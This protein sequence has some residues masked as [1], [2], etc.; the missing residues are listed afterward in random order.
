M[1]LR[2]RIAGAAALAVAAVA[3]AVAVISYESTRSHL[4]YN[5]IIVT[6]VLVGIVAGALTS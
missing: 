6:L 4:A 3:A 1:S 5:A 2:R